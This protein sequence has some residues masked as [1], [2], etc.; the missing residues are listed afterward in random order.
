MPC[1]SSRSAFASKAA[2][3]PRRGRHRRARPRPVHA[4]PTPRRRACRTRGRARA[5][6]RARCAAPASPRRAS[7][8]ASPTSELTASS[9][10]PGLPR[11]PQ[12]LL[13][14][15]GGLRPARARE[16][17]DALVE[18][19]E[20]QHA[21]RAALARQGDRP[22][23]RLVLL[24][25][26]A[27]EDG[28]QAEQGAQAR[29]VAQR[30]RL[31][32][33]RRRLVQPV[34][35]LGP[36]G[37]DERGAE[38]A[39]GEAAGA[40]VVRRRELDRAARDLLHL[41]GEA[42]AV[43]RGCGWPRRA[44]PPPSP[45]PA[46]RSPRRPPAASETA[47]GSGPRRA[48]TRPRR[49]PASERSA[50]LTAIGAASS[51]SAS[52]R[53]PSPA[54]QAASAARRRRSARLGGSGLRRAACSKAAAAAAWPPRSP[55]P[56]AA[57]ASDAA[58]AS[59]ASSVAAATC[60]ARRS[61]PAT[62]SSAAAYARC[63]AR[64]SA[65]AAR[66]STAERTSGW[67]NATRPAARLTSPA[68]SAASSAA[69]ELPRSRAAA[70]TGSSCVAV[71]DGERE[72][73]R[74]RLGRQQVEPPPQRPLDPGA[75]RHVV[76][77]RAG[78]QPRRLGGE[79]DERERVAAGRGVQPA[80]RVG[81]DGPRGVRREQL[82]RGL[83]G[84]SR[85]HELLEPDAVD[86][87]RLARAHGQ[88]HGDRVG[89]QPPRGERE[90]RRRRP[91]EP[92]HVVGEDD[93]G[94]LLRQRREQAERRRTDEVGLARGGRCE[95]E[96]GLERRPL[97]SRQT[98]ELAEHGA[99]QLVQPGEGDLDLRLDAAH[100]QHRGSARRRGRV[101]EQRRLADPGLAAQHE[102]PA[103]AGPGLCDEPLDALALGRAPQ[104][105]G[106]IL[107]GPGRARG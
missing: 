6:A 101:L 94:A 97:R 52:A 10:R 14:V 77:D 42:V 102:H 105:H 55:A 23:E 83:G 79:L 57:A 40:R 45:A 98:A 61:E 86:R 41:G 22:H 56:A 49:W 85:Q 28:R 48:S 63:A 37:H 36:P 43:E 106:A 62:G 32:D 34:R 54:S 11:Q 96:R 84:E 103:H 89:E 39:R 2:T 26:R 76:A 95:P 18:E 68:A 88:Q 82:P 53:G 46:P 19:R 78:P 47:S 21:D 90:R 7:S 74:P 72:H 75:D 15:G 8:R 66:A 69:S 25:L 1:C 81:R 3:A 24:R 31:R 104:Q 73:G 59:S 13:E 67:R 92:L 17:R 50:T 27:Q 87:R 60:Q 107:S 12:R 71:G 33:E 58:T 91:V 29:V 65:G 70:S 9:R 64:R 80:G 16:R 38:R 5:P 4:A 100:A 51:S 44:S 35:G 99:Q 30:R 20:R 93:D